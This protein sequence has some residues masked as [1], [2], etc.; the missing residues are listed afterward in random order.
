[1]A[2]PMLFQPITLRDLV[3][4][5]RLW[6]PPMC[7]YSADSHGQ[8]IGVATD[9]HFTHITA[10]ARGGAG[11][12]VMEATGV[13][14]EGRISPRCLGLWND[15]QE[16]SLAR[17]AAAAKRHGARI[18]VQLNHAGRKASTHPWLPGAGEGSVPPEAH[19]WPTVAPSA[20]P[21]GDYAVPTALTPDAIAEIIAAF[22]LAAD[23]AVR[24]G[25]DAVEIHAAHGYLLHQF[26]SPFSNL[27]DDE[28]GGSLENRAR[29]LREI[30]R[31]IRKAHPTL[32]LLV[33]LSG[34]EWVE[35]GFDVESAAQLVRWLAEDGADFIDASSAGNLPDVKIPVGPS[36]QLW[37][38]ERLRS[39]G[40]PVG[41][42]GMIVSPEQAESILLS[43]QA[44]VVSLGSPLLANPH[45]PL[46]WAARLRASD[47]DLLPQQY[48]RA[49]FL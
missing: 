40:L 45:V 46:A 11:L 25:F 36:Y 7:Q 17:I 49:R 21:F 19:G 22:L 23:R 20:V 15:E 35:G 28:Y 32:P 24:A 34:D 26:L 31:G 37:I 10:L 18:A 29:P 5:N 33:R 43:G 41:T 13:V 30:V 4:R 3:I 6:V 44:D 38:A 48:H 39:E 14:P 42:V 8:H 1:M 47:P 2:N 12:V 9:W 16:A 27:R